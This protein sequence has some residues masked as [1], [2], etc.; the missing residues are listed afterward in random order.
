MFETRQDSGPARIHA[1]ARWASPAIG[2][3]GVATIDSSRHRGEVDDVYDSF[4][5]CLSGHSLESR[6]RRQAEMSLLTCL[7][8]A[9]SLP[10]ADE[11]GDE[12]PVLRPGPTPADGTRP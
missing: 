2:A 7:K 9:Y 11:H 10:D 4:L 1:A 6:W 3:C 12:G 8:T 5:R